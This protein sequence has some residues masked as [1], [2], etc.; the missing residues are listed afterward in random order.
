MYSRGKRKKFFL[1]IPFIIAAILLILGWVVMLLWNAILPSVV[2][3]G[4][5]SYW[6]AVGLL[7]LSRI[8]FGFGKRFGGNGGFKEN[9]YWKQ[10]W[11]GMSDEEK[12]KF[13]EQ[14]KMRCGR[15]FER[16]TTKDEEK[17]ES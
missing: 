17:V 3:A 9:M 5:I 1:F 14:W 12:E 15:R 7:I 11:A 2:H 6:Q 8:L 10:R 4:E 13:K 16:A